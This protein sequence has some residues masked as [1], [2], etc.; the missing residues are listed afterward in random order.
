MP[1]YHIA[2]N[3][4]VSQ[5]KPAS[6]SKEKDLQKLFEANLETLLGVKFI[7]SEF[8]TGDRQRGRIDTLGIDEDGYPTIIEYKKSSKDNVINQGLFYLDWLVDHKGDFTLAAQQACGPAVKID[9]NHPRLILIAESFSEYDKYAVNRIGSNIELWTYRLYGNELLHLEPIYAA[10]SKP[11]KG[12]TKTD[13]ADKAKIETILEE[14]AGEEV[15]TPSYTVEDHLKGRSAAVVELFE[16]LR[17]Y[18]FSLSSE[19]TIIE[20]A[21]KMYIGYKHGKNF[22]EIQVQ[23]NGLRIWLDISPDQ[24]DDPYHLGRDVRKIGHHGTGNV[25]VK[26][27][28]SMHLERIF[29]LVEQAYQQTL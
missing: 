10:E 8:T 14:P 25:E 18:I 13:E 15:E 16:T 24:L 19:D 1:L 3:K 27:A 7:G 28:N 21:N 17:E 12:Q 11:A 6:F 4:T 2:P 5:I 23:A 9:W 22:V 20:K 29:P 26:L